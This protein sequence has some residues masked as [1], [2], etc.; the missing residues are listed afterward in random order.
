[1]QWSRLVK[2]LIYD[3]MIIINSSVVLTNFGTVC[4]G[5]S[6][7]LSWATSLE[8]STFIWSKWVWQKTSLLIIIIIMHALS[9][10]F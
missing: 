2:N 8:G 10:A 7:T 3:A 4:R 9:F 1:M 6:T 5:S